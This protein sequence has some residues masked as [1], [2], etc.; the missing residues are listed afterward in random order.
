MILV[1]WEHF[2][3][4]II[5]ECSPEKQGARENYYLQK[6]LPLLNTTFSSSFSESAIY[7]SLNSQ[8]VRLR[9]TEGKINSQGIP[10]YVYEI[11][12][13]G[14][15]KNFVKY[16]S[17]TEASSNEKRARGTLG[18][19]L[20]TNVPFRN[21]LYYS[22]PII[23]FELTFNLVKVVSKDL[24]LNNNIA[25]EVWAYH[26]K[27]LNLIIGSP[28][29]SKYQASRFL[30]ISWDVITYFIDTWK[31]E[32]V[33]N[34]Y[35]FS[36]QLNDK[37]VEKLIETTHPTVSGKKI[38]VWVYKAKTLELIEDSPFSSLLA[39]AG[40]F[41]INPRTISRH[42]DTKK[43]TN[44]NKTLVYF[45]SEEI[46]S[47]LRT[48]L[49]NSTHKCHYI[50]TELWVYQVDNKGVL[51][52]MANQP[53]KTKREASRVLHI[54]TTTLSRLI[55]SSEVYKGLLIYSSPQHPNLNIKDTM[56]NS[57]HDKDKRE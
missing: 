56:L 30:G 37:E 11:N 57:E 24:K 16:N 13:E 45:F 40:Y 43:A 15:N 42:L 49:L 32:G 12:N 3:I 6:Y 23:D 54:H 50:H 25:K 36:R 27:T 55:D 8:L 18:V 10:V 19:Y 5:E 44:Q 41:N 29:P 14:I 31:P 48:E 7:T 2:N 47:A 26:A 51:N 22:K 17:I 28:F 39:A 35:L 52:L 53:F 38:K 20:D 46:S 1:G 21:K 34:T 33:K 4:S 9:N